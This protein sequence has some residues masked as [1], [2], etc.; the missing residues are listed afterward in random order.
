MG[1]VVLLGHA[2]PFEV[3]AVVLA[4]GQRPR[5]VAKT[6]LL[7]LGQHLPFATK[8]IKHRQYQ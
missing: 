4:T 8:A 6:P 5:A 2:A 1:T 3:V 7:R